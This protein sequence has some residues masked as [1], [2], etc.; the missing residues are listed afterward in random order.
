MQYSTVHYSTIHYSTVQYRSTVPGTV[1]YNTAQYSTVQYI[2]QYSTTRAASEGGGGALPD[3]S[4]CS[5]FS[6]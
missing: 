1:Q 2:V 3:F 5:L 4:V 6:V